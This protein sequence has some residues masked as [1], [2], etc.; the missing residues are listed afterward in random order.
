MAQY[1]Q[2]INRKI[3]LK[4]LTDKMLGRETKFS[5]KFASNTK[6]SSD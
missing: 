1:K 3:L 5:K 4:K 2:L 6:K